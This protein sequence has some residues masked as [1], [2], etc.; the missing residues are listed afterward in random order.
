[1]GNPFVGISILDGITII[2]SVSNYILNGPAMS[3]L[4]CRTNKMAAAGSCF[5]GV[6][7]C[8]QWCFGS[9]E[10]VLNRQVTSQ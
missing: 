1:M 4:D 2:Q 3:R 8:A 6:I 10:L 7:G 5:A 9:A